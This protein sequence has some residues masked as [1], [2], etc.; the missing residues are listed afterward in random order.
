MA[1]GIRVLAGRI[2]ALQTLEAAAQARST[3]MQALADAYALFRNS[4]HLH[5]A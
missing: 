2:G 3:R 4:T 1:F 5:K